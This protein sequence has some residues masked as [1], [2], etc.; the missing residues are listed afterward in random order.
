MLD[1]QKLLLFFRKNCILIIVMQ[2]LIYTTVAEKFV[3]EIPKIKGSR[4]FGTLF[5]IETKEQV[6]EC[7]EDVK[8]QFHDATH[9]CYA[10]RVGIHI[11]ED[12]F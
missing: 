1:L 10:Y 2:K 12:L 8:K 6:E 4:F 9:N 11:R 5:P 3:Y 7:I